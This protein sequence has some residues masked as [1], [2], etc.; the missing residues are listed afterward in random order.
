MVFRKG[1][2]T[3]ISK[4]KAVDKQAGF[5]L[6]ELMVVVAII[7]ILAAIG[8]PRMSAFISTAETS[9]AV[10][11]SARIV[12]AVNGY[13]D[14]HPRVAHATIAAAIQPGAQGELGSA[15]LA[16]NSIT[17]LIPH[18]TL[19]DNAQFSYDISLGFTADDEAAICVLSW[20]DDDDKAVRF[21]LYSSLASSHVEWESNIY[22]A[23]YID[24]TLAAVAGGYCNAVG[25]VNIVD[26]G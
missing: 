17:G 20:N 8:L 18:I 16:A 9:E 22:R 19:P 2:S 6:V 26:Q 1:G 10:E 24:D 14:S 21:L 23:T 12:K 7:A 5:T 13:I 4:K 3:Q 15:V 25:T 11:Q